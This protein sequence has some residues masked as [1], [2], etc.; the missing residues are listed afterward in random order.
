MIRV[1]SAIAL[2]GGLAIGA[3]LYFELAWR[4]ITPAIPRL[5]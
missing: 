1:F 3:H 2:V 5:Y 4:Q